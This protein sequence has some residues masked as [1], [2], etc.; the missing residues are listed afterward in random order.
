MIKNIIKRS[1]LSV[2]LTSEQIDTNVSVLNGLYP[3]LHVHY[4]LKLVDEKMKYFI[5]R[6]PLPSVAH[7]YKYDFYYESFSLVSFEGSLLSYRYGKLKL[8]LEYNSE[9]ESFQ[10]SSRRVSDNTVYIPVQFIAEVNSVDG[11][12]DLF[13]KESANLT[14][15]FS[16]FGMELDYNF[17]SPIMIDAPE[18]SLVSP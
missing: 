13:L 5:C 9:S 14:N 2:P 18:P 6:F 8:T 7:G 4:D 16:K 3:K 11:Y 17:I 1:G 12:F 10:I 15:D